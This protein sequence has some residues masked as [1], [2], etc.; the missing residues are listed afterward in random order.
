MS[1][2][3]ELMILLLQS[4][5]KCCCLFNV[6]TQASPN[7][8]AA[9]SPIELNYAF[10]HFDDISFKLVI[11]PVCDQLFIQGENYYI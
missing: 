11:I 10:S 5:Q 8:F 9:N 6:M 7:Q 2:I 1:A 4:L 3:F